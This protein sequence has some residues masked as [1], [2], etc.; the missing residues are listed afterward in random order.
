MEYSYLIGH[1]IKVVI[2]YKDNEITEFIGRV[3][4]VIIEYNREKI[5][6]IEDNEKLEW[7]ILNHDHLK[8]YSIKII[9]TPFTRFEIMDI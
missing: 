3:S 4:K 8:S 7:F 5:F 6:V 9:D 1:R 2:Y